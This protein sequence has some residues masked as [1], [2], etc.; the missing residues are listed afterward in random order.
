ME[1]KK[2]WEG[3]DGLFVSWLAQML[4][5]GLLEKVVV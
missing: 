1:N 2:D 3:W 4:K 5:E